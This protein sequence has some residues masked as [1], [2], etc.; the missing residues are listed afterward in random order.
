MRLS[1][2]IASSLSNSHPEAYERPPNPSPSSSPGGV[3][4]TSSVSPAFPPRTHIVDLSSEDHLP[5]TR[6]PNVSVHPH[7]NVPR[8]RSIPMIPDIQH[9]APFVPLAS[10][11]YPSVVP[12][13]GA[14]SPH[15]KRRPNIVQP[16]ASSAPPPPR[17]IVAESPAP[18][19]IP[20]GIA[21]PILPAALQVVEQPPVPPIVTQPRPLAM[22]VATE[23]SEPLSPVVVHTGMVP[24]SPTESP[25]PS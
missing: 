25:R 3:S 22:Q 19:V 12:V 17:F 18:Y 23:P 24:R 7:R 2:L 11:T 8:S 1:Q 14:V 20:G 5:Y 9:A 15:T 21:P 10:P 16:L 4:S 13:P 6:Q